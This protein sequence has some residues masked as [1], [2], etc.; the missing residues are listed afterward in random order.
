MGDARRGPQENRRVEFFADLEGQ[1]DEPLCLVRIGRFQHGN[2]GEF[3]VIPVVLLVLRTVQGRVVRR[4]DHQGPVRARVAGR[5]QRI[6]RH[7]DPHV[8]H[9]DQ[10]L[11]A[12]QRGADAHLQGHLFVGGPFGI[13]AVVSG[14]SLHDLRAGGPRI[15]GCETHPELVG[16]SGDCLVSRHQNRHKKSPSRAQ[17]SVAIFRLISR[18]VAGSTLLPSAFW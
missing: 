6:G 5:E 1:L 7:V 4:Y 13:D 3:R 12:G 2:F 8:L 9:G 18:S 14:E 10:G 15:P 16:T 11:C 17:L